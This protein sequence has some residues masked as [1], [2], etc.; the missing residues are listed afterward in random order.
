MSSQ[1]VSGRIDVNT[2]LQEQQ[3]RNPSDHVWWTSFEELYNKRLWHQLTLKVF[4]FVKTHP[5]EDLVAFYE[6]FI[7]DFESKINSLTLIEIIAFVVKQMN[8]YDQCLLFISKM[9]EKVRHDREAAILCNI[10]SGQLKLAHNDLKGVKEIL[11]ESNALID[12]MTGITAIHAR[13][14]QLSSDYYQIIGNHCEY[15]HDALRYLGCAQ[16]NDEDEETRAKRAF[17]LALAALLGESIFNF[18][19]LLQH[20]II[21]SL[22]EENA[23]IIDLLYAFNSG[24]LAKYES[25]RSS[26]NKQPDLASH[27][28]QLRQKI[29]LLCLMEM[30]FKS[31]NGV[32][33]FDDIAAQTQLPINEIE[34]LIMKALSLGLVK[35]T[36]DQVDA[37]VHLSWVQ[38]RVLDKKQISSMRCKLDTWFNDVDGMERL[39]ESRAQDI[40]N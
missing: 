33:T 15:Y 35:G 30:T 10:L 21:E 9:K 31:S 38:P 12:E 22:K 23:W 20:T 27:E 4:Q 29:S 34:L 18:G 26:W 2:F 17:T 25:L 8:D 32:L 24:D 3:Q 14:Y 36:I 5:Q 19:E 16:I 40:I 7:S 11:E 39:L 28:I 37:K 6:N 1:G 13:F